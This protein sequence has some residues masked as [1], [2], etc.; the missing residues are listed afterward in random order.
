[1]KDF[2]NTIGTGPK[3]LLGIL[4]ASLIVTIVLYTGVDVSVRGLND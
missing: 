4:A 3:I 1:M 2:W